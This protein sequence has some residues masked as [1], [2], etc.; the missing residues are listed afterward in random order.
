M[1]TIKEDIN[2]DLEIHSSQWSDADLI[3]FRSIIKKI[4]SKKRKHIQVGF[5][6]IASV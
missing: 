1:K 5:S 3:E 4:K 2:I 6:Q